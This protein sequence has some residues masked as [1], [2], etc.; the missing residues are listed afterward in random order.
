MYNNGQERIPMT[1][2]FGLRINDNGLPPGARIRPNPNAQVLRD[3]TSFSE[4][5]TPP[6]YRNMK[7]RK[8]VYFGPGGKLISLEEYQA[9]VQKMNSDKHT[10][11]NRRK[12]KIND[13][14]LAQPR[15]RTQLGLCPTTPK[16][17][18]DRNRINNGQSS[19]GVAHALNYGAS[20]KGW[21]Q[22]S[23]SYGRGY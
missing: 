19:L 15:R 3:H 12:Q 11:S 2:A 13:S 1:A 17:E 9:V 14:R 10:A 18:Y 16:S 23:R 21:G 6:F 22:T 4:G 20:P 5:Q 7:N 8:D